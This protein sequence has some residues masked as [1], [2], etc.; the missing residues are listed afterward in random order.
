MMNQFS[1]LNAF[2]LEEDALDHVVGGVSNGGVIEPI[3]QMIIDHLTGTCG[4][5]G[6][7]ND[8]LAVLVQN[9]DYD[10]LRALITAAAQSQNPGA[11][12]SE[13]VDYRMQMLVRMMFM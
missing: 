6:K 11:D 9:E 5:K 8:E 1:D 2:A 4:I 7:S 10:Q 3:D 12:V 13:I